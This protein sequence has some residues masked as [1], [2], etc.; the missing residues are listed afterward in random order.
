MTAAT[1]E[2][3]ARSR[4]QV[5]GATVVASWGADG[6]SFYAQARYGFPGVEWL[7]G[8]RRPATTEGEAEALAG[9]LAAELSASIVHPAPT[10][11]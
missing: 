9:R 10:L 4:D 1:P 6:D 11:F 3:R 8:V 7:G 2:A 5:E